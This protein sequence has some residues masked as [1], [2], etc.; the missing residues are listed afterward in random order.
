VLVVL[1]L[2]AA[3]MRQHARQRLLPQHGDDGASGL[4]R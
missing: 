2:Q 1:L 3:G 4:P